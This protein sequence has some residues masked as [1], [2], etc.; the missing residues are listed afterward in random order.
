[1]M[2]SGGQYIPKVEMIHNDKARTAGLQVSMTYDRLRKG[3]LKA[4]SEPW[5]SMFSNLHIK[6]TTEV[7]FT[8]EIHIHKTQLPEE[9]EQLLDDP[10]SL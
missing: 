9:L 10:A 5:E 4:C 1:M 6:H 3:A 8:S 2:H 7:S